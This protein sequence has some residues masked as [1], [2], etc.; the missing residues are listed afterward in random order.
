MNAFKGFI[1]KPPTI[2]GMAFDIMINTCFHAD[3]RVT[4]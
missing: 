2:S 3:A 4:E 1:A